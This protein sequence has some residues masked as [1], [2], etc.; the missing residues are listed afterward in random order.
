MLAV[1]GGW[2]LSAGLTLH[3]ELGRARVSY[4]RGSDSIEAFRVAPWQLQAL[5][6]VVYSF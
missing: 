5:L 1:G 4:E 3:A 6:G 2:K